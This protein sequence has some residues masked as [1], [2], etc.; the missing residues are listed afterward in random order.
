MSWL[1][2]FDAVRSLCG[3][4]ELLI[5]SDHSNSFIDWPLCKL[6]LKNNSNKF[7]FAHNKTMEFRLELGESQD[8]LVGW[9][10]YEGCKVVVWEFEN[11]E[12]DLNVASPSLHHLVLFLKFSQRSHNLHGLFE[13]I[14]LKDNPFFCYLCLNNFPLKCLK[15]GFF[16]TAKLYLKRFFS[17][18]LRSLIEEQI[19]QL[20]KK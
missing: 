20:H 14:W 11:A 2:V 19:K 7:L 17:A 6:P 18:F 1:D 13:R 15:K 8:W 10:K 12:N 16:S 5:W 3:F 4:F 9:L